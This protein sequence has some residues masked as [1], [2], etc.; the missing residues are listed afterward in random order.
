MLIECDRAKYPRS[1]GAQC[2]VL[3]DCHFSTQSGQSALS[4]CT[5]FC[6][7]IC[8]VSRVAVFF[9]IA[10]GG[11][12]VDSFLIHQPQQP[13]S[14]HQPR[15]ESLC[16]HR[17]TSNQDRLTA[18]QTFAGT[19]LRQ[20]RRFRKSQI[21]CDNQPRNSE[22]QPSLQFLYSTLNTW[23]AL[24]YRHLGKD[25]KRSLQTIYAVTAPSDAEETLL[26]YLANT[27]RV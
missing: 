8:P 19:H 23:Q 27:P 11:V 6:T 1:G 25:C 16:Y 18:C 22:K 26:A 2:R 9:I 10:K 3:L 14:Q 7:K 20:D 12:S 17:S 13:N 21:Y 24:Y 4:I 15:T 5:A